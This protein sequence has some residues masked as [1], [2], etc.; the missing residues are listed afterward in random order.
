MRRTL[1]I[2]RSLFWI[3]SVLA[4]GLI[5]Y[6]NPDWNPV[7]VV[8][9]AMCLA[10]LVILVDLLLKGFSVR[11]M[12]AASVGLLVGSII[13]YLIGVSPLFE[14]LEKDDDLQ[15]MVFMTRLVLFCATAITK[16]KHYSELC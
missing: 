15:V 14:P 3:L 2:I 13:A 10:T 16:G 9:V 5:A 11:G 6:S 12:T 1:F 8:S 7:V 4:G